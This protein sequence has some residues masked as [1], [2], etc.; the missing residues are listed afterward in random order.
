MIETR[1]VDPDFFNPDPTF[2]LNPDPDPQS[3]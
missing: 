2:L 3:H 1:V